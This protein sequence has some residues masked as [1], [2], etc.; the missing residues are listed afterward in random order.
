MRELLL[1]LSLDNINE[2]IRYNEKNKNGST[3]SYESSKAEEIGKLIG[4][5]PKN[6]FQNLIS[7]GYGSYSVRIKLDLCCMC[8]QLLIKANNETLL[9][10]R[11]YY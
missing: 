4:R 11:Q 1:D 10:T 6:D 7:T 8:E 5:L 3:S 9:K 2:T